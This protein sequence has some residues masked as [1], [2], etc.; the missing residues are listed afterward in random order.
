V[1]TVE[2]NA[3]IQLLDP[4][5]LIVLAACWVFGFILKR[6]PK[7]PNWSIVYFVS[8]LAM[9]SSVMILGIS[10]LSV[11]QG[12]ITGAAAVYGYEL[13]KNTAKGIRESGD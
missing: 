13:A 4:K 6:T 5:L 10:T 1:I 7:V 8:C 12:L 3:I 9:V 11:L 2:W